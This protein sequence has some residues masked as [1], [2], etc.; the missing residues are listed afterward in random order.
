MAILIGSRAIRFWFPDF[1]REPKDTDYA[2]YSEVGTGQKNKDERV[3]YLAN[4]ILLRYYDWPN[5]P[6]IC[7]PDELYT[8]KISHA[9]G[10]KLENGSWDKHIWDI[11][12]LKNKG[13]VLIPHLF[14]QLYAYW[15]TVHGKNKRSDLEMTAEDF[16]NNA[17]TCPYSHDWLHTLLQ[18][19][20]T[21]TKVLKDGAEVE[22]SEEKFNQLTEDEKESLV[23][24]EVM[25]MAFERYSHLDWPFAYHRMV[26][27]FV[28]NHAPI[29]EAIWMIENWPKI[30]KAKFNFITYL[31]EKIKQQ[32]R[33]EYARESTVI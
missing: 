15:E 11:T 1:P 26:K 24:E 12:W 14:D 19:T 4:P 18:E 32:P 21:Y 2:V 17:L 22:V 13:C 9:I 29:W 23:R 10:W 5:Y 6:P 8:L 3:E 28:L 33:I 7:G 30:V 27:K 31:N 25:V 20:P 16:F